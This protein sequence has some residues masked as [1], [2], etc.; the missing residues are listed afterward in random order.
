[1]ASSQSTRPI[2]SAEPE[3]QQFVSSAPD[4]F[5]YAIDMPSSPCIDATDGGV[6]RDVKQTCYPTDESPNMHT[7]K[8]G[9]GALCYEPPRFPSTDIPFL[10]CD[11]VQ[12]G[13]DMQ[14]EFSP[15][16]IR[17]FM[18]S[19]MNCMTPSRLWDSPS[20][21]VGLVQDEHR[22]FCQPKSHQP[23]ELLIAMEQLY[24]NVQQRKIN[25]G[26]KLFF[27]NSQC[28]TGCPQEIAGNASFEDFLLRKLKVLQG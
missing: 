8:E 3:D 27:L 6:M 11:L 20:C 21:D 2:H 18:I 22:V 4:N 19:S 5:T 28:F 15:L 24:C 17:Q 10:N 23:F 1:M 9:K 16:G 12:S 26:N 13:G 25:N 7:E 14:Q